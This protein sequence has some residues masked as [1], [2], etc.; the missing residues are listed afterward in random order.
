MGWF[1]AED[2]GDGR[3]ETQVAMI[4]L[5]LAS[6]S[7]QWWFVAPLERRIR[8]ALKSESLKLIASAWRERQS[9]KGGKGHKFWASSSGIRRNFSLLSRNP[10][11]FATVT[12]RMRVYRGWS[13]ALIKLAAHLRSFDVRVLILFRKKKRLLKLLIHFKKKAEAKIK[14]SQKYEVLFLFY[15]FFHEKIV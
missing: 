4:L 15:F 12:N 8:N 2:E 3:K 1:H 9:S 11:S 6:G 5:L 13:T 10:E 14:K 7:L